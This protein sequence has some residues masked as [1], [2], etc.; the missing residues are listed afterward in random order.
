[1]KGG[2]H[3]IDLATWKRRLH[4]DLYRRID[5]PFFSV[6]VEVDVTRLWRQCQADPAASFFLAGLFALLRATNASEP[7]RMR[8]RGEQVWLHDQVGTGTPILK[9]DETFA[10]ARFDPAPT[11]AAFRAAGEA[12][13]RRAR[14]AAD[15]ADVESEVDDVLYHSTLPW[16]RFTAFTNALGKDSIPRVVF[17]KVSA[18][19]SAFRMPVA[20]EVHHA[21]VDGLDVARFIDAFQAELDALDL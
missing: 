21:L 17:G 4:F 20:V 8:L 7:L 2:G 19:G 9:P 18:E 10:F 13:I 15:L 5:Y 11:Y 1:V 16:L 6:T 3:L 14:A 12:A